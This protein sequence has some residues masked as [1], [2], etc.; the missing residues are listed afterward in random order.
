MVYKNVG[1]SIIE[2]K[3]WNRTGKVKAL[4][5]LMISLISLTVFDYDENIELR[6]DFYLGT[7]IITFLLA[8]LFFPLVTKF[9]SLLGVKF[10]KPNWNKNPISLNFP[11]SLNLHYFIAFLIISSGFLKTIF[12]A[13]KFQEL[14]G[15]GILFL[16]TGIGIIIGLRLSVAWLG[17]KID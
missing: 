3:N 4:I 11:N 10:K 1:N 13:I 9:W 5:I 17:T 6:N 14:Y 12:I 16:V 15:E 8:L 2:M 7:R